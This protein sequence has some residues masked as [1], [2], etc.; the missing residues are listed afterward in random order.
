MLEAILSE[1]QKLYTFSDSLAWL[2]L[3]NSILAMILAALVNRKFFKS[4]GFA[5]KKEIS[6]LFVFAIFSVGSLASFQHVFINTYDLVPENASCESSQYDTIYLPL[7]KT[8]AVKQ[9]LYHP[10]DSKKATCSDVYHEISKSRYAWTSYITILIHLILGSFS[11]IVLAL[12]SARIKKI[13]PSL[14]DLFS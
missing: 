1:L 9:I 6:I 13:F 8:K 10:R 5:I 2:Y 12:I 3:L 4:R 14:S 7:L 11:L